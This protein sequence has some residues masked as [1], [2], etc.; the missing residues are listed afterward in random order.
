MNTVGKCL[1]GGGAIAG[2]VA[3]AKNKKVR[4]VATL[5]TIATGTVAGVYLTKN[6]TA[7][8]TLKSRFKTLIDYAKKNGIKATAEKLFKGLKDINYKNLFK[9]LGSKA[10]SSLKDVANKLKGKSV[11]DIFK[12]GVNKLKA[13]PG[14]AKAIAAVGTLLFAGTLLHKSKKS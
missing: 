7:I 3:L 13:L 12:N 11:K 1:L 8:Q 6:P 10:K 4:K 5:G 14:P 2:T 9:K